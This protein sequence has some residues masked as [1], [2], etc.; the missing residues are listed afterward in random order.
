MSISFAYT[1]LM[2]AQAARILF[3]FLVFEPS[4]AIPINKRYELF[5]SGLKQG[6]AAHRAISFIIEGGNEE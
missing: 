2:T 4:S 3:P 6:E 5:S 1:I